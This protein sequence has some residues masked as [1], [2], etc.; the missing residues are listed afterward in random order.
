MPGHNREARLRQADPGFHVFL[1]A[2]T[3]KTWM[4]GT[5]PA[6]TE[7]SGLE[8]LTPSVRALG[9]RS[10][11]R[12]RALPFRRGDRYCADR[13]RPGAP[14]PP[15]GDRGQVREIVPTP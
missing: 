13:P 9:R 15:S 3:D 6:M 2:L 1:S 12:S 8:V 11:R 7:F 14:S 10:R 5:S 4:A